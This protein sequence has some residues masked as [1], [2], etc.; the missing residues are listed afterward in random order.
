MT[1]EQWAEIELLVRAKDEALARFN[2]YQM[3]NSLPAN[4][5]EAIEAKVGMERA[6]IEYTLA[7]E[8]LDHTV[9]AL[10]Q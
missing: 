4:S 1:D 2:T 10:T 5:R 8:A 7:C 9:K 3:A 6:N